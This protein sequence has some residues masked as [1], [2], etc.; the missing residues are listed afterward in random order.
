[1]GDFTE[2]PAFRALLVLGLLGLL[3]WSTYGHA[4]GY[5]EESLVAQYGSLAFDE[6]FRM[7]HL[8]S[9]T[10]S[11]VATAAAVAMPLIVSIG[12]RLKTALAAIFGLSLITWN[13]AY[14]YAALTTAAPTDE[15]FET[16]RTNALNLI[17]IPISW[18][19]TAVGLI[20][21][22]VF[23]YDIARKKPAKT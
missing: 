12:R 19:A 15:A 3:F 7:A 21:F 10:N 23:I 2:D 1:M 8:H 4:I 13:T 6:G 20:L 18:I 5:Y 22:V 16:A 11:L 14:L 9:M 17:G